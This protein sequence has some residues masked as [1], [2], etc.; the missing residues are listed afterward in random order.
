VIPELA[1]DRET[2]EQ[3]LAATIQLWSSAYT[4]ANGAGAIDKSA[5]QETVDFMS[6]LPDADIPSDLAVDD[7]VTE[8][9]LP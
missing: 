7:L 3:I 5:W 2:Q 4:A 9:F 6:G 8:E 1:D